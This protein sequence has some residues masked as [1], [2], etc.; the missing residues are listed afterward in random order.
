MSFFVDDG[1]AAFRATLGPVRVEAPDGVGRAVPRFTCA[2]AADLDFRELP[3]EKLRAADFFPFLSETDP[4][5]QGFFE[6]RKVVH[7]E[8][9]DGTV[10]A[11]V[12]SNV[13]EAMQADGPAEVEQVG[14]VKRYELIHFFT[15][16][17]LI[18]KF[19]VRG[20]FR[21]ELRNLAA[22]DTARAAR[23][24]QAHVRK[25]EGTERAEVV[26]GKYALSWKAA[27]E[28][29]KLEAARFPVTSIAVDGM[30]VGD[31]IF[32][33]GSSGRDGWRVFGPERVAS[34]VRLVHRMVE[35]TSCESVAFALGPELT[36]LDIDVH[37]GEGVVSPVRERHTG[38]HSELP[39][40]TSPRVSALLSGTDR[41]RLMAACEACET[42]AIDGVDCATAVRV[43]RK[44]VLV[45]AHVVAEGGVL[46][47]NGE[48]VL[49]QRMLSRDLW[50]ARS[51]GSEVAWHLRDAVV[52][53]QV[54]LCYRRHNTLCFGGPISVLSAGGDVLSLDKDESMLPGVSGAAV[55]SLTDLAL[56][57]V[58]DGVSLRRG[59]AAAYT[60]SMY[61]D[62]CEM[63]EHGDSSH[64]SARDE[65]GSVYSRMR[66]RGLAKV[67]DSALAAVVP[68]YSGAE[69]VGMAFPRSGK[70]YT[71]CDPD[72]APLAVGPSSAPLVFDRAEKGYYGA[73]SA[74]LPRGPAV[75]RKAAYG[76]GVFV[77]GRD[78]DGEYCSVASGRVVHVGVGAESFQL[79]GLTLQDALP[80]QGGLVVAF[81][82]GA[83]IGAFVG[84]RFNP[85]HGELVFCLSL[86]GEHEVEIVEERP[87]ATIIRLF[88]FLRPAA[89]PVGLATGALTHPSAK[90]EGQGYDHGSLA[91]I[92]DSAMRT[93]LWVRLR[94]VGVPPR[95]W[96]TVFQ[97]VQGN[98]NL[99][100]RAEALGLGAALRLGR[101]VRL[102]PGA[103]A[104]ADALEALAGAVY[105]AESPDRF[106]TFCT[107]VGAV[108]N[109]FE[110]SAGE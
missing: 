76:E 90:I 14:R 18:D 108:L 28:T 106:E 57:G 83:V 86:P 72:V 2:M 79:A 55:V 46:T 96:Q 4:H 101:G 92:G 94:E 110:D 75:V 31:K 34:L 54:A 32:M 8:M 80:L 59:L 13:V 40:A 69:H 23:R 5:W 65:G 67:V 56:L 7:R 49:P 99:A 11:S 1:G 71:V 82:D 15:D 35:A 37:D 53:E 100:A 22:V 41:E 66:E 38:D 89:W 77:V 107:A 39:L 24:L 50:L 85:K 109:S 91:M 62:T 16:L 20:S 26:P 87:E 74:F 25:Y 48:L 61:T 21:A 78:V 43:T 6:T 104:Y 52:G 29:L 98:S 68:L 63:S 10:V 17:S 97:E 3:P 30:F 95:R 42:V 93:Q 47:S 27:R 33:Y 12:T 81:S 45:N 44:Y 70:L 105:L 9:A 19:D 73:D 51:T 103:K 58:Y 88:P 60:Q 36:V 64:A 102:V 84:P